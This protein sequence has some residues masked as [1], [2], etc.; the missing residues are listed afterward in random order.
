MA[1]FFE[2]KWQETNVQSAKLRN[3]MWKSAKNSP[4]KEKWF[5]KKKTKKRAQ[6]GRMENIALKQKRNATEKK[7]KGDALFF[8]SKKG[9][10][11]PNIPTEKRKNNVDNSQK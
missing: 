11:E 6:Q 3:L 5:K 4:S 7:N 10:L 1:F 8:D 9:A 2:Q